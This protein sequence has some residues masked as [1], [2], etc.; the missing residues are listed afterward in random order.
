MPKV[1]AILSKVNIPS[2]PTISRRTLVLLWVVAGVLFVGL[3]VVLLRGHSF[4]LLQTRG[5]V[6]SRQRDLLIFATVLAVLVLLPVYIMLFGFAWRYRAGH[7][8]TYKPNWDGDSRVE[9]VWWGVPIII[10]L[11][12]SVVTWV[13]SHSLDPFKPLTSTQKPLKIQ[14][15]ALQWKWLFIYPE[16]NIAS[17]NEVAFPANQP[18]E[19]SI[20]SDAPMNSFWIPQL[21]G[22]IYAMSGMSTKLNL[23]ADVVGDYRGMSSN[24][25]GKGFADMTFT[26]RALSATGYNNW[27]QHIEHH[28]LGV[29]H[30]DMDEY[31][32]LAKPGTSGVKYFHI[33][34]PSIFDTVVAKYMHG[35]QSTDTDTAS[36]DEDNHTHNVEGHM[37]TEDM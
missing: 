29:E 27:V 30:L 18:V 19:F 7:K 15:I 14:V 3:L 36:E 35:M 22:Q 10:I 8:R 16:E 13:T 31:K 23:K 4:P 33:H 26:A 6:A 5:E 25:S 34:D 17:V 20:T 12:L 1:K 24:I 21:G 11:V 9:A 2:L 28:A 37:N 32:Q